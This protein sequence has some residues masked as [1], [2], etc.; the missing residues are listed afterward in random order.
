MNHNISLGII[1]IVIVIYHVTLCG[2][3]AIIF[4]SWLL[5]VK[6]FCVGNIAIIIIFHSYRSTAIIIFIVIV[7]N[8]FFDVGLSLYFCPLIYAIG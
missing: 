6:I 5:Y 4:L 3:K 7:I 8:H 2:I 1:V